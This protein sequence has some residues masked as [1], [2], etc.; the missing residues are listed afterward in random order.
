PAA[1]P[2]AAKPSPAAA[3]APA[4]GPWRVQLG[5]FGVAANADALWARVKGRPEL[6]G[7]PR[8]NVRSGAVTKLQATGFASREA[9]G[10][11]CAALAGAGVSCLAVQD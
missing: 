10:R 7:H 3:P 5:A 2:A 11:A 8:A 9:A 6:A 1:R 4:A